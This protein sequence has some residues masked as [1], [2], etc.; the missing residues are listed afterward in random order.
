MNNLV[1]MILQDGMIK[2]KIIIYYIYILLIYICFLLF[3]INLS[4][5]FY[6]L[7]LSIFFNDKIPKF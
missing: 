1:V 6:H 3:T 7:I 5:N 2:F 4:Y